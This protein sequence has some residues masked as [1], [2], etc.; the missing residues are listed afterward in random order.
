M[1]TF[2]LPILSAL[3]FTIVT[4]VNRTA[5][6][7]EAISSNPPDT[8]EVAGYVDESGLVE[9]IPET[10]PQGALRPYPDEETAQHALASQE[11]KALYLIPADFV[12]TGDVIF[13]QAEF[14]LFSNETQRDFIEMLLTAN[15]L[16]GD[17]DLANRMKVPFTTQETS[18]APEPQRDA[19]DPLTFFLPYLLTLMFYIIIYGTAS[20]NISSIT[21]EKE[22]RVIEILMTSITPRQMFTGKI[23]G[24]GLVGLL[25]AMI[26]IGTGYTLNQLSGRTF[27]LPAGISTP[28]LHCGVGSDFFHF[29]LPCLCQPDGRYWGAG[30]KLTRSGP[31]GLRR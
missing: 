6:D 14:D 18:L 11:I 21:T 20:H 23:L 17:A 24:L 16:A 5:P 26:W 8:F 4:A 27:N 1:V 25:Q 3:I 15:L 22:N 19:D 9:L 7:V 10:I 2:G 28:P 12:E 13:I 29:G 31:G 30:A